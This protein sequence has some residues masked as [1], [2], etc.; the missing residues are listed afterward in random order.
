MHLP[1]AALQ[2]RLQNM[3]DFRSLKI[4][5]IFKGFELRLDRNVTRYMA[6]TFVVY[7]KGKQQIEQLYRAYPLDAVQPKSVQVDN[8]EETQS[9]GSSGRLLKLQCAAEFVSGKVLLIKGAQEGLPSRR[10]TH[11]SGVDSAEQ[12]KTGGLAES[13]LLP[14]VSL[15]IDAME[16]TEDTP[17]TCHIS[18]V[19][20]LPATLRI[21]AYISCHERLCKRARTF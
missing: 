15:W 11:S 8:G 4:D 18:T 10:S 9:T 21:F 3:A 5:S 19:S 2:F 20:P 1:E 12:Q 7:S 14:G 13:I 6:E 16:G 17:G